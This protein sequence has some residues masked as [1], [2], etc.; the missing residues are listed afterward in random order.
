MAAHEPVNQGP[1]GRGGVGGAGLLISLP[2]KGAKGAWILD[3]SLQPL[4]FEAEPPRW[5]G[6][7]R[8]TSHGI[9][10]MTAG[11]AG[12]NMELERPL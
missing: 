9:L 2:Q 12:I 11:M 3:F 5:R 1:Q 6:I 7:W 8:G 10:M 4:A